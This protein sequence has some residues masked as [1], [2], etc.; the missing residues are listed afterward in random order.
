LQ[1]RRSAN[2]KNATLAS[3]GCTLLFLAMT[4]GNYIVFYRLQ[5]PAFERYA[6]IE[7][8]GKWKTNVGDPVPD[9]TVTLLNGSRV[10]LSELHGKLVLLQFFATWCE[11][12]SLELPHLEEEIWKKW[13]SNPN[14]SMLV[15]GRDETS[16]TVAQ[17]KLKNGYT[18]PMAVDVDATVFR[19]FADEGFPRTYLISRDG[20]ILFQTVGFGEAEIYHRE[21]TALMQ[22]INEEMSAF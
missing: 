15:I 16:D 21:F 6:I 1:W 7:Q 13:E 12:C 11:P 18:F 10:R 17:F 14:F 5:V 8:G 9:V 3:L 22:R 19:N 20:K 4:A 2:K